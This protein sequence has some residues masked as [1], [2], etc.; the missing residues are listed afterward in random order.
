[1]IILINFSLPGYALCF[2]FVIFMHIVWCRCSPK[3]WILHYL[4]SWF[5]TPRDSELLNCSFSVQ[6]I[7]HNPSLSNLIQARFSRWLTL[8]HISHCCC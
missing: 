2:A 4:Q 1:L 7:L 5:P 6:F 3:S 8:P